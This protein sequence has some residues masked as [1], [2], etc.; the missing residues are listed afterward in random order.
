MPLVVS[1]TSPV[2]ALHHLSLLSLLP[3]LFGNVLVPPAVV[4]ELTRPVSRYRPIEPSGYDF[5]EQRPPLDRAAVALLQHVLGPGESEAI[6]LAQE[7][8]ADLLIDE[9]AGRQEARQR[10]LHVIGTTG[11]L[12]LAKQN[13]VITHVLPLL[14]RLHDEIGFFVSADFRERVKQLAGE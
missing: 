10:G 5:I 4:V 9:L 3:K 1:D 13:G 8:K 11:V 2:R 7:C 6:V 14:D 12:L